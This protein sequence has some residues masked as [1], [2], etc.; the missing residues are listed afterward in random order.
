MRGSADLAVRAWP[1]IPAEAARLLFPDLDQLTEE[2]IEAIQDVVPE[3]ARPLDDACLDRIRGAVTHCV[4]QFAARVADPGAA[5]DRTTALLRGFGRQAAAEG[6]SLEPVQTALRTGGRLAWR[7]LSEQ[8]RRG[9]VDRDL[10]ARAGEAIFAYL[11][12]LAA[13]CAAGFTQAASDQAGETDLCRRRLLSVILA[14][15]PAAISDLA[16]AARW[17]PPRQVAAVAL[18][19]PGPGHRAPA[20]PLPPEVLADLTRPDPCLL[21][22][23]PDDPARAAVVGRA[24]PGWAGAVGPAVPL[25][26]ASSSLRWARQALTLARRGVTP[27]QRSVIHC[28]D[29]LST[30]VISADEELLST[31]AH[32]TLE[33]LRQLRPAQQDTLAQTLLCWLQ[34]GGNAMR[35]ARQ[36]RV[37][38]QTARYRLRQLHALFGPA[39]DHAGH[40]FELEIA[41]RARRL[42]H[43]GSGGTDAAVM[44]RG[45]AGADPR[46]P[47]GAGPDPQPP[48]PRAAPGTA[49]RPCPRAG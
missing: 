12:E 18:Q 37:H 35:T 29:L 3:Y 22:P 16:R 23:G 28:A 1:P 32:T 40:R 6:R 41:L 13:A 49:P 20:P 2:V 33:P 9:T 11:D 48:G 7:R 34:N 42:L 19:H 4:H 15:Q 8:A 46:R 5:D 26:R 17:T 43:A 10:L 31:L 30:L 44:P 38:P 14:G 45:T 25:A 21:I 24:L 36:L 39:L 47:A 27:P